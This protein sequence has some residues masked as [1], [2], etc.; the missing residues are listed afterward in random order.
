MA[1]N[2]VGKTPR[3]IPK[4]WKYQVNKIATIVPNDIMSPVAKLA[5]LKIPYINVTKIAPKA[6]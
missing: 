6:N 5:N 1:S 2:A 4:D 3:L